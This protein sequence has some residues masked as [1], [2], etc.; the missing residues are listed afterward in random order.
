MSDQPTA[1]PFTVKQ[2]ARIR[3]MMRE[4]MITAGVMYP[5]Y[6][7]DP[8]RIGEVAQMSRSS[9][10][11]LIDDYIARA[12]VPPH[13][14]TPDGDVRPDILPS[15]ASAELERFNRY[16]RRK[17]E[18]TST[19]AATESVCPILKRLWRRLRRRGC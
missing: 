11:K 2:E 13:I 14:F 8:K 5:A 3:E 7:V 15:A 4:A 6:I 12:G 16:W 18:S 17:P 10:D 9:A 19:V 1:G